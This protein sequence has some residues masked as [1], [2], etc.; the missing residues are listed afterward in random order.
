[1]RQGD[2]FFNLYNHDFVR[3]A[4]G[5]PAV[6]VADPAFNAEQTIVLMREAAGRKALL[7]LFP[8]LGLS[9]YS[10]DDLFH[11]RALLDGC[12]AGLAKI[13]AASITL[14]LIT[15]VGVPLEVDQL[16]LQ[17][18][19]R[20]RSRT[21]PGSGARRPICPITANSTRPGN[22]TPGESAVTDAIALCGQRDIPFGSRILFQAR[23]TAAVHFSHRDL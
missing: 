8:E 5:V 17:L 15:V 12:R 23:R 21:D 6:R 7:A 4:V 2:N 14:P 19:R 13:V 9:A 3:V 20:D 11:Q 10:C 18:C 16:L 1:M 22:S